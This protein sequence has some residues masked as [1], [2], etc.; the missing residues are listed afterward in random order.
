M[1]SGAVATREVLRGRYMFA[2]YCSGRLWSLPTDATEPA[3]DLHFD[4]LD[5]PSAVVRAADDSVLLSLSG[6]IWRLR[7]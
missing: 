7:D 5:A 6:T 3:A 1:I 4:A 2:D